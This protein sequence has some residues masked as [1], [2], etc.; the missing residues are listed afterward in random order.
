MLG[1]LSPGWLLGLATLT[2]PLALHLWS[3]RG[4]RPIRV[5]SIRLLLGAPAATRRS[6]SIRDPA[7]LLLRCS[8]LAALVLALAR[9]YWSPRAASGLRWALIADDVAARNVLVDSLTRAG[10]VVYPL[11]GT[12]TVH[13]RPQNLWIALGEADRAAP[14]GTRFEVFGPQR[15]RYFR[16]A[17][18]TIGAR[19]E[20][21]AREPATLAGTGPAMRHAARL[22]AIVADGSRA[23]DARYVRAAIEAAGQATGIAAVVTLRAAGPGVASGPADWIVWLSARPVP[24]AVLDRVRHGATLLTDAGSQPPGDRRSRI[25]LVDRPSEA[26]L[27][28]RSA[29]ADSAAPLWT[30]GTGAPLLTVART[31][32]GLYYRFHS[33]FHPAWSEL[34]LRAEFPEALARLWIG[35]DSPDPRVD[36]RPIAVSQL[37]PARDS[38][39]SPTRPPPTNGRS[40]F[41]PV[42]LLA[43]AL[44]TLE[45]W[46]TAQP[47]RRP[48]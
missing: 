34:V 31:G 28:R 3:R 14:P 18:P 5:G 32:R 40:L 46:L 15:L 30:D 19:V 36:D 7:L 33:R 17:R 20:W 10:L 38:A 22:V 26:W 44:F 39:M 47:R 12:S 8:V 24:G 48:A 21:H 4:G 11:G 35:P 1:F 9:P 45:R 16:G 2:L 37:L 41:V 23:E 25:V 29:D 6:W 13:D 42:W 43:L 27:A